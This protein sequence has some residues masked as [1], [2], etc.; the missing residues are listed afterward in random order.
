M[1]FC[2]PFTLFIIILCV[3]VIYLLNCL[4]I[5]FK[6][7]TTGSKA[8]HPHFPNKCC[9]WNDSI[10]ANPGGQYELQL[11]YKSL[12]SKHGP[13]TATALIEESKIRINGSS[14]R[15]KFEELA[16]IPD[17]EWM[18]NFD[19][20]VYQLYPQAVPIR[21]ILQSLISGKPILQP[22]IFNPR[23]RFLQVPFN[24]CSPLT[25]AQIKNGLINKSPHPNVVIIYKSGVY[26]FEARSDIRR[27]YNLSQANITIQLIFSIGL[28]RTS[29]GNVFQRDGFNITLTNRAGYKLLAYSRSPSE[30]KRRLFKEMYEHN[31]L[32]LGDYEDSYYNFG[33]LGFAGPTNRSLP[34]LTTTMP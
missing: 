32:L 7:G 34:F 29:L 11:C 26:N 22:P 24:S 5:Y 12:H 9:E 15:L 21:E 20:G 31:D 8:I 28:P 10:L 27:L 16:D 17:T 33:P 13:H 3:S 14:R 23:I 4:A 25:P 1:R 30:M 19:R 2:T 6:I 18:K